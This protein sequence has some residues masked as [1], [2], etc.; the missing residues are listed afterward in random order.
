MRL[1]KSNGELYVFVLFIAGFVVI[2]A[3]GVFDAERVKRLE[4]RV[5]VLEAVVANQ[6]QALDDL[7]AQVVAAAK[8]Q[9][10]GR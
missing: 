10:P 6:R 9:D 2:A 4:G 7:H 3:L 1:Q 8:L 5:R